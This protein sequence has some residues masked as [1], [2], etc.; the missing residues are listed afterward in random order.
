MVTWIYAT[1][2]GGY[3]NVASNQAAVVGGGEFNLADGGWATVSGGNANNASGLLSTVGGGG[4]LFGG[5]NAADGDYSTISGGRGNVASDFYGTV[6][7]GFDNLAASQS[8]TVSGGEFNTASAGW[9]TVSGGSGNLASGLLATVAG[10]GD[11]FGP[12]NVASGDF[13]FVGGG[14]DNSAT[15]D[16]ATVPGGVSSTATDYA[17]AAGRRALSTNTGAFVW[18]DSSAFDF[19]SAAADEFAA[20][21]TGGVRLVS[22]IDGSGNPTAGV[23][24]APGAT[25]WATISDRDQK[26]NFAP[27]DGQRVL[28]KLREVPILQWNYWWEE[29]G[30]T[31]HVGPVAQEFKA[32][33]YPGADAKTITTLELDGVAL[34]AIQGLTQQLDEKEARIRQLEERLLRLEHALLE[35]SH[36]GE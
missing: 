35:V 8:A 32:A 9:S 28:E 27:V 2:S 21:A 29:D 22:A 20:R 34:A 14:A 24:L 5:G 4:D 19:G 7:G 6:A 16:Y 10:G 18:A 25:A 26:K 11:I 13:S 12:G 23:S 33:F 15:G 1:V 36:G 30:H 17:L 3:Q 31:P